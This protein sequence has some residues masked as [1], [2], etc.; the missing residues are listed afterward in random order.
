[1]NIREFGKNKSNTRTMY[2]NVLT[3]LTGEIITW[4]SWRFSYIIITQFII[5]E[6]KCITLI[7]YRGFNEVV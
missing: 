5:S 6:Q 3:V 1:M 4:N 2:A 7:C